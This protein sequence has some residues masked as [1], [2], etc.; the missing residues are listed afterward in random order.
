MF[1]Q[2]S[3][4][5]T[6]LCGML[7]VYE[8]IIFLSVL[9][10]VC[11]SY[12]DVFAFQVDNIIKTLTGHV[13][14]Q[15]VFQS[16]AGDDPLSVV[17]ESQSR[18]KISV[19]TQQCFYKLVLER[20]VEEEGVVRFKEDISTIFFCAVFR[21]ITLQYSFFKN[22]G[23]YFAVTITPYFKTAAE[24]V[25]GFDADTV[26]TDAFF[27]SFAVIFPAGIQF[28]DCFYQFSLRN[29]PSV[30]TYTY[31]EIVLDVDFNTFAGTHFKFIDAVVHH[32]FQQYVDTVIILRTV[33]KAAYVHARTD[34]NMLHVV[35]MANVIFVVFHFVAADVCTGC[36][37][38]VIGGSF[39][40][41][42]HIIIFHR[43]TS[44]IVSIDIPQS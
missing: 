37:F 2:C 30:I 7:S 1:F 29:A 25:D 14:F 22:Y 40:W 32:F 38:L 9:V 21:Y 33:A 36:L 10:G 43:K 23:T 39:Q 3:L 28:A 8:R 35:Q 34:T 5:R 16:M 17:D 31:A 15:Q 44:C 6:A 12:L 11:K 26:Q 18:I 4:M 19:V 27:E 24:C 13:V 41:Q 20:V 42:S